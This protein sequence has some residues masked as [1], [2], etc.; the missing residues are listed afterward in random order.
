M[1]SSPGIDDR[2][3]TRADARRNRRRLL[4]ATIDLV[5]EVGGEPTRDSIAQRA[6]VG[7]ATM[8]R[9]FPTQQE[10]LMAV[11]LDLLDRA[12]DAGE[13]A[14]AEATDGRGALSRYLHSALDVGLGALSIIHPLLESPRW[15]DR[16]ERAENLMTGL[17]SA[18]RANREVSQSVDAKEIV[19]A[20]LRF[21]RPLPIGL[22]LAEDRAVA[23]AQVDALLAGMAAQASALDGEDQR[24]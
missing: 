23:H 15:P 24:S 3:P 18:A 10:L 12:I 20:V 16:A 5:L 7:I 13:T 8:Y 21:G 2:T 17:V 1:T 22:P 9:H 19:Y 11:A 14:L 4:D 6:G